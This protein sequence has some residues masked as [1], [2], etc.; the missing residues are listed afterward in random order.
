MQM[1]MLLLWMGS[2]AV[3]AFLCACASCFGRVC[4]WSVPRDD[5]ALTSIRSRADDIDREVA[6]PQ[7]TKTY[8]SPLWIYVEVFLF[9]LDFLVLDFVVIVEYVITKNYIFAVVALVIY[10]KTAWDQLRLRGGA[11]ALL[12]LLH[13]THRSAKQGLYTNKLFF[14]LQSEKLEEAPMSLV[15]QFYT[16]PFV[17]FSFGAQLTLLVSMAFA[18]RSVV[19]GAYVHFHLD[20]DV[21]EE[22]VD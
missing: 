12:T 1:I 19:K 17:S 9:V 18:L 16:L 22:P 4:V 11:R 6:D 7:K 15:L 14:L 10:I 20:I 8:D 21:F 2:A 13:E 5:D 3:W